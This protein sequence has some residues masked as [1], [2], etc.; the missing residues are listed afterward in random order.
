MQSRAVVK[1]LDV[2]EGRGRH[3]LTRRKAPAMHP[4][5]LEAVEPAF[6]RRIVSAVASRLIQ[7]HAVFSQLALK[8]MAG[9]LAAPVGVMQHA[10][11]GLSPEP[12]HGQ[13]P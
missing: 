13:H 6:R 11:C 1:H 10:R 3:L 9:V 8:R 4:L 2:L 7:R 5:V 12:R